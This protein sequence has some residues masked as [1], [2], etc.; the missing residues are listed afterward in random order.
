MLHAND[1]DLI[2]LLY[3]LHGKQIQKNGCWAFHDGDG[4]INHDIE[5]T[6]MS[7]GK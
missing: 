2:Q 4:Q 6:G 1:H 5:M 3:L 7:S